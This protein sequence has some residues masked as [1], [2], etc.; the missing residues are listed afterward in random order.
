MR[1]YYD[2]PVKD[3][4]ETIWRSLEI[5]DEPEAKGTNRTNHR[6]SR[7]NGGTSHRRIFDD[8]DPKKRS[9][10]TIASA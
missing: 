2:H 7:E 1:R 8:D 6:S 9:V 5:I 3:N 10:W 4:L